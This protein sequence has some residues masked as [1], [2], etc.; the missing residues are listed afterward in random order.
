L[1][2]VCALSWYWFLRGRL[3]EAR[4]AL[5]AALAVPGDAAPAVRGAARVWAAGLAVRQAAAEPAQAA[6]VL[7][8]H[9]RVADARGRARAASFLA[10][11]IVGF[12]DE[13]A[14]AELVSLAL[15][16]ARTADDRWSEAMA[17]STRAMLAHI[18]ND[19]PALERDARRSAELFDRIGDAWGALQATDWLIALADLTGDHP[20]AARL[21]A[22]D[23]RTAE[24]LGLWPD[25]AG[26]VGWLAWTSLQLAD[27][28]PAREHARRARR[29]A[30]EHGQRDG[31]VFATLSLAFAARRGGDPDEA[32]VHLRWLL[33]TAREQQASGGSPPYLSMVLVELGM[34]LSGRGEP[35]AALELHEEALD[36]SAG[37]GYAPALLGMA[38]ALA[39]DGRP[40]PAAQLL[41]AADRA[42][43]E[44]GLAPS[45]SDRAEL[46][47]VT[48]LVRATEPDFAALFTR[49]TA[50]PP[51]RART[52]AQR[53]PA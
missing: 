8:D 15:D 53:N 9:A 29:L 21:A 48:A 37:H 34:L 16:A 40:G 20:R 23:L 33:A 52:L 39:A 3:G 36:Q 6:A 42:W 41:G 2:L 45:V 10:A 24:E 11:S 46:D 27:Y 47:R 12:G 35:S 1:R 50:L 5:A 22:A 25:V 19:Q 30:A 31:E 28:P 18:R 17:L 4:R 13:A 32:E 26:R 14:T 7:R 43:R 44:V 38:D 49:G 51:E